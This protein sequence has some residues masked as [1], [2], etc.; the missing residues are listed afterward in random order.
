M[1]VFLAQ[2]SFCRREANVERLKDM[3][4]GSLFEEDGDESMFSC[5]FVKCSVASHKCCLRW[6][7]CTAYHLCGLY[8]NPLSFPFHFISFSPWSIIL[9]VRYST[10]L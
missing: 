4:Q 9:Q 1:S 5:I 7:S 10:L 3:A 6:G 2:A 8:L